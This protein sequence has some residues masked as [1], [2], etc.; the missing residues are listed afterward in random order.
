MSPGAGDCECKCICM[1][2]RNCGTGGWKSAWCLWQ[3]VI[4]TFTCRRK[5]EMFYYVI[6]TRLRRVLRMRG[7]LGGRRGVSSNVMKRAKRMANGEGEGQRLLGFFPLIAKPEEILYAS[8][9]FLLC[10]ARL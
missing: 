3:L 4:Q 6:V 2:A 1:Y 8:Q 5:N 10:P 7:G 9:V